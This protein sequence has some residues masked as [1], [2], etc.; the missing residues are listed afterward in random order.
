ML[1]RLGLRLELANIFRHIGLGQHNDR[2]AAGLLGHDQIAFQSLGIEIGVARSN[3]QQRINVRS[4]QLLAVSAFGPSLK[5][6]FPLEA[7]DKHVGQWIGHNPI[8]HRKV[9]GTAVGRELQSDWPVDI[10]RFNPCSMYR[11]DTPGDEACFPRSDLIGEEL[12]PAKLFQ[13]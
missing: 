7:F 1:Q 9:S 12:G 2:I 5:H 8:A 10:D 13:R 6:A 4:N 3:D 11:G